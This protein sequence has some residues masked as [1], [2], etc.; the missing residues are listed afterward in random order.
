MTAEYNHVVRADASADEIEWTKRETVQRLG[1]FIYTEAEAGKQY[2]WPPRIELT[3][4]EWPLYNED[5]ERQHAIR[6]T[7]IAEEIS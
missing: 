4:L 3:E 2:V 7:A 6:I 1:L 5:G